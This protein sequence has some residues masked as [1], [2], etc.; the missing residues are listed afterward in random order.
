[1]QRAGPK[2]I[3]QYALEFKRAAVRLSEIPDLEVQVVAEA[4]AIH[5][6]MLSRW[7]R[8]ARQKP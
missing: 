2:Q 5:P 8:K 6:A 1:M 3:Q 7:R 4:L